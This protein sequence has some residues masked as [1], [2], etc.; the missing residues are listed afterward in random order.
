MLYIF[1]MPKPVEDAAAG[2]TYVAHDHN[3]VLTVAVVFGSLIVVSWLT[4]WAR[5]PRPTAAKKAPARQ[6][7]VARVTESLPVVLSSGA[8]AESS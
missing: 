3:Q 2:A 6:P 4:A 8:E 7:Q 5:M 1:S